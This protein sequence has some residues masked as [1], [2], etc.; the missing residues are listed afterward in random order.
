MYCF[1]HGDLVKEIYMIQLEGYVQL[2]EEALVC[3]F[4]NNLYG[5]K[6]AT[7]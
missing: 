3:R 2:G 1:P 7:K 5:F 6:Q 4:K